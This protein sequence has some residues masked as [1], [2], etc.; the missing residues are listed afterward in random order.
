MAEQEVGHAI[1]LSSMLG[2]HNPQHPSVPQPRRRILRRP[3]PPCNL[4]P[5]R[6]PQRILALSRLTPT[7]ERSLSRCPGSDFSIYAEHETQALDVASYEGRSRHYTM[8]DAILYTEG[9][10]RR[11]YTMITAA[12]VRWPTLERRRGVLELSV[13]TATPANSSPQTLNSI[14]LIV[15]PI[16]HIAS[17]E[18]R[19]HNGAPNCTEKVLHPRYVGVVQGWG[20]HG[21]AETSCN[22]HLPNADTVGG[23]YY[24]RRD[25]GPGQPEA[26]GTRWQQITERMPRALDAEDADEDTSLIC[27]PKAIE[28]IKEEREEEGA[29][30]WWV[31]Y[32]FLLA[33]PFPVIMVGHVVNMSLDAM[34]QAVADG[35]HVSMYAAD[36]GFMALLALVCVCT[37]AHPWLVFPF[38]I[39]VL[40]KR[41]S[42]S[43]LTSFSSTFFKPDT[44][45]SFASKVAEEVGCYPERAKLGWEWGM[46]CAWV[47]E[48]LLFLLIQRCVKPLDY[49][50]TAFTSPIWTAHP[51]PHPSGTKTPKIPT[52]S[53]SICN[54]CTGTILVSLVTKENS[55]PE[56]VYLSKDT[57]YDFKT[58]QEEGGKDKCAVG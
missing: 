3:I 11:L 38:T 50:Y 9:Q 56:N 36:F 48:F 28:R 44:F 47:L 49:I 21:T 10:E 20:A 25:D 13:F 5:T 39:G 27:R 37:P 23:S 31:F 43:G 46:T 51:S 24:S 40:L 32:W 7:R 16:V 18:N 55:I 35:S 19:T 52:P 34:C 8:Y 6:T 1:A 45:K 53:V 33:V 29:I 2:F 42:S 17:R 26:H 22:S 15:G 41:F 12:L 58:L 4:H 54:S 14:A 57:F 30:G